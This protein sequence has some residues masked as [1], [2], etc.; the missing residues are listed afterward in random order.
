LKENCEFK[1]LEQINYEFKVNLNFLEYLRI[2]QCLPHTWKQILNND[3]KED[4]TT[5]ILFNKMKRYKTLKCTTIYWLTI[6]LKHNIATEPN[7]HLYWKNLYKINSITDYLLVCFSSIRVT[8][9]QALQYKIINRI[10]NCNA[11]L[12]KLKIV[13]KPNCRFCEEIETIEHFFSNCQKTKEYWTAIKNWWNR[14]NILTI[15][16]LDEKTIILGSLL[17]KKSIKEFNCVLMIAKSN[18][19]FC[20]SNK[21][22]PDFYKFLTQFKYFLK[23]EEEIHIKNN[24]SQQ[25]SITWGFIHDNL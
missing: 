6:A 5:D 19:H 22:Q 3:L 13:E 15:D 11:W 2:R 25:F 24:T 17:D 10:Y 7:S 20:K 1:S 9:T 16:N 8:F 21:L 23:I 18:I 12:H 14:F 4:L